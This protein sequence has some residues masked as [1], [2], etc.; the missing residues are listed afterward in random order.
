MLAS[1]PP[2]WEIRKTGVH[3]E[4]HEKHERKTEEIP[5]AQRHPFDRFYNFF[6][7]SAWTAADL[8]YHVAVL[9]VTH[10]H[11]TA[12]FYLVVDDT[13]RHKRGQKVW[14]IGWFRDAAASTR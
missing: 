6:G 8:A 5:R 4:R 13:L 7:R 11:P 9:V 1:L 10:L 2:R 3:H 12:R 14:G